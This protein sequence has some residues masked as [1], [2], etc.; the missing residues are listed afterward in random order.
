MP[1]KAILVAGGLTSLLCFSQPSITNAQNAQFNTGT[2][3]FF[4]ATD[5]GR[6]H[7]HWTTLK[8]N[9][10]ALGSGVLLGPEGTILTATHVV[11]K[12]SDGDD[13]RKNTEG[14]IVLVQGERI[15]VSIGSKSNPAR[16]IDHADIDCAAGVIDICFIRITPDAVTIEDGFHPTNCTRP[17]L[18]QKLRAIG[19][20]GGASPNAGPLQPRGDVINERYPGDLIA[21]NIALQPTMSGG[22]VIDSDG[23]IVGLVKGASKL[24]RTLTFITPLERV[25][26][27]LGNRSYDCPQ[28][29]NDPVIGD[30]N[31]LD[32]TVDCWLKHDKGKVC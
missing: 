7:S 19:F 3:V 23:N 5:I 31:V 9:P 8:P 12:S 11:G 10:R 1:I 32:L 15:S 28:K 18:D 21:T 6:V 27:M 29:H 17:K 25:K 16:E 13:S 2:L 30:I 22:P 24:T 20:A 4:W 14:K 26:S